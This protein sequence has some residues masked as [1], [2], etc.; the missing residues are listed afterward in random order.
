MLLP[1]DEALVRRDPD[2]PAL[3][4][5]LD[6]VGLGA[7]LANESGTPVRWRSRY[8][9]YKRGTSCVVAGDLETADGVRPAFASAYAGDALEKVT[10]SLRRAP[11]GSVLGTD[12]SRGL[13]AATPAADRDLP[14]LAVLDDERARRRALRK[15]LGDRAGVRGAQIR[16]LSYK[17][18]R[19]WVGVVRLRRGSVTVLRVYR[20]AAARRAVDAIR[21]CAAED[22]IPNLIGAQL[23]KGIAAI[24]Y[25]EGDRLPPHGTADEA[26]ERAAIRS[27]GA[28]LARLHR[29]RDLALQARGKAAGHAVMSAADQLVALLPDQADDVRRL[30]AKVSGRLLNTEQVLLP[31]HGDFSL[32]QV[33]IDESGTARLIDLDEA[34]L[35][36]PSADLACASAALARDVVLGRLSADLA[37]TWL[38]EL[39]EGYAAVADPP[40]DERLAVHTAA[41]LL[42]RAVE[43]FRLRQTADWPT[44]VRGL[45]VRA[46]QIVTSDDF[47]EGVR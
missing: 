14:G 32:D 28:T 35:G 46:D 31:I 24:E 16:A 3:A 11:A 43:P 8:L 15:L 40:P 39:H 44:A 22:G 6:D 10:K 29:A 5:L 7:W 42:R 20:P 41:H 17:P 4:L 18:Q 33:V 25:V 30:S 38:R 36:D 1:A 34:H 23:A 27:A 45:V 13:V 21:V 19:R 37:A 26:A 9:R 47:M 2:L 12:P